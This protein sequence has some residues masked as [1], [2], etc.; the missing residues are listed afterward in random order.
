MTVA[1][2][3]FFDANPVACF[4]KDLETI[5]K[6]VRDLQDK[7]AAGEGESKRI[8]EA[9]AKNLAALEKVYT[10]MFFWKGY[11]QRRF[12][13]ISRLAAFA[14]NLSGLPD[15]SQDFVFATNVICKPTVDVEAFHSEL[16]RV[17]SPDGH[18]Y[19]LDYDDPST[20]A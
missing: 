18:A 1:D 8:R 19:F 15:A 16:L 9:M 11:D 20:N 7:I 4:E 2:P 10:E 14:E 5:R 12:P 13:S 6:Q 17:L 3:V